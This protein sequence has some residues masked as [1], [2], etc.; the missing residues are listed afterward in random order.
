MSTLKGKH[1]LVGVSG[2]IAAYKSA[3]LVRLLIKAG[4]EVR[5]LLTPSAAD[6]ITPLTLS[7]L[8]K[9][10]VYQDVSHA[11]SWNNHVELGLWADA[12]L[13]APATANTIAK[14]ANGLCDN[15]VAAVYLSARC[16]VFF[17]PAMDLDMWVHPSTQ[18][19]VATLL[20]DGNHLIPV[21]EGELASGLVGKG[22]MAEPEHIVAHLASF[23]QRTQPLAGKR[24]I[25]TAGPTYEPIDP[26]RFIGNRSSGKMGLALAHAAADMG[27]Q[28]DLILGPSALDTSH[29]KVTIHRVETALEMFEKAKALFPM[30]DIGIL[31][32]AVSDY[33]PNAV[34]HQKIKKTAGPPTI[35]LVENP[36]IA[37][38]LGQQKRSNQLLIGFALETNDELANAERKLKKKNFDFIVLN[39]LRDPGAGF[40]HHTNRI[41]IV[42]RDNK[43]Q[44]FELK[45][46]DEVA[47]DILKATIQLLNEP[48]E[49]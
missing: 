9:H 30:A 28:V 17:A 23:W 16:P 18:R 20:A 3:F 1:I 45:T 44:E 15:M 27:A 43:K 22:R 49:G 5:V 32:A 40:N 34:S 29:A 33:R 42:H 47:I 4:A 36:D 21:E 14:M 46:K 19:N 10:P 37:A 38:H 41:T 6:F 26:V 12:M 2:S 13:V 24:L 48:I 35:H 7:T 25:L 11:D 8:S 39:S 31:A